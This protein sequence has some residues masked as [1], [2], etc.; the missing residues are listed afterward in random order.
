V[1]STVAACG[2][3]SLQ[4]IEITR[5]DGGVAIL[6]VEIADAREERARGLSSRQSLAENR[7]MLFV[8]EEQSAGFWMRGVSIP[9]SIAFLDEC[10]MILD[11]QEMEP[12]SLELHTIEQPYSYALEANGGWFDRNGIEAG[13]QVQLPDALLEHT[14]TS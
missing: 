9:L 3:S 12:E 8:I 1:A 2:R 7:G 11:V 14:C 6:R 10:G 5:D 4:M 13:D